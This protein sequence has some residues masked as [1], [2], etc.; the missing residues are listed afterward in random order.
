LF[1]LLLKGEREGLE[2]QKELEGQEG[3]E[4]QKEQKEQKG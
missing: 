1:H 3:L 4:E 2:E